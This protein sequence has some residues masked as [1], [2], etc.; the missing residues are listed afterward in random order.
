MGDALDFSRRADIEEEMDGPCSYEDLRGCLRHL[1][2]VNRITR[3]HRPIL[4][5]LDEVAH[6]I[7][8]RSPTAQERDVGRPLKIVDVGSGYG[9]M[10]RRIER[11][12]R[13]CGVAVDLLGV[14]VNA[15]SVRAAREATPADSAIRWVHGDVYSC[16][17]VAEADMFTVSGMTHHLTEAEIVRLIAWIEQASRLGWFIVDLHRK[18]VPYRV[19]DVAMR[20][21]WWHRFIRTDGLRSLRR[22]FL[23]EDWVR[24]CAAAGMGAEDVEIREHRPARLCVERIK[25]A[26]AVSR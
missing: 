14:D 23:A 9:D 1:A 25:L 22:S 24:M 3:A 2:V 12:A 8:P 5:W 10:L 7:R 26:Q 13:R 18:P 16:A 21:P 11:W 6:A 4:Q 19:F 17:E 20:G 15:N